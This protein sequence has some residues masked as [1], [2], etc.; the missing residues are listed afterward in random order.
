[1]ACPRR[2]C[3]WADVPERE[4]SNPAN[5]CSAVNQSNVGLG[6]AAVAAAAV[7]ARCPRCLFRRGVGGDGGG[8]IK[9]VGWAVRLE[10][11]LLPSLGLP[12][13]PSLP[14]TPSPLLQ[15]PA[16]NAD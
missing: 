6:E 1:M 7:A 5:I 16:R 10:V 4:R 8:K 11:S 13:D 3:A 2:S 9:R 14:N 12:P 15:G